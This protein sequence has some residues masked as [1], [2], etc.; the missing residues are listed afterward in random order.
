MKSNKAFSFP[1]IFWLLLF[2]VVPL[3]IVIYFAFTTCMGEVTLEN[4]SSMTQYTGVFW[5]SFRLAILSTVVCLIL[6]YPLAY[7]MSRLKPKHRPS[8]MILIM[9]PM[10]MNFLVRTYAWLTILENNGL[11]NNFLSS[12]HLPEIHI[13]NTPAAVALGMIYN[14]LPFMILPIYTVMAKMDPSYIEAAKDMGASDFQ[15]FSKVVF[16]L[17]IP[18]VLSGIIMVFVPA[19]S[20]FVISKILGGGANML[21]GDL[22]EMQFLGSTYNANMGA[23]ISLVMMVTSWYLSGSPV[24]SIRMVR[25]KGVCCCEKIYG[26]NLHGAH[27]SLYVRADFSPHGLLVQQHEEPFGVDGLFPALVPGAVPGRGDYPRNKGHASGGGLFGSDLY[28]SRNCRRTGD[29]CYE[30]GTQKAGYGHE[31]YTYDES[32][33]HHGRLPDAP[34]HLFFADAPNGFF[35]AGIRNASA[36]A[37]HF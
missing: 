6:G 2:T 1:Y 20:T 26:K 8:P 28:H 7:I 21:V 18:G 25:E 14:Y 32:G 35:Y 15:V 23:A 34:F 3:F 12:L 37:Y 19:V 27:F 4:F 10:W 30:K 24:R 13:I 11:L 5:R 22:I 33:Y 16:P 17:S 29:L 9:L 36:G 31:Q